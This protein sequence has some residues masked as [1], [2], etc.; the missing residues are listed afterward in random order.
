[1]WY[2]IIGLIAVFLAVIGA[3]LPLLPTTIFLIIASGCFAK[4]SP[5]LHKK[6]L[7]HKSFGPM[8][9]HWQKSGSITKKAKIVALVSMVLSAMLSCYLL[10]NFWLQLL[11]IVLILCPIIIVS[12]LPLV[13][14][15]SNDSKIKAV[16]TT[17]Q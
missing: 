2:K 14:D 6:L 16:R 15:E 13:S 1:M 3:I 10:Q 11:V 4:S 12:R 5:F 8:L 9:S 17:G 7:A